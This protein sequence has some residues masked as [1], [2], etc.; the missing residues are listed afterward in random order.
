MGREIFQN[1]NIPIPP[2]WYYKQKG[3]EKFS[4]LLQILSFARAIGKIIKSQG[5]DIA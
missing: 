5:R 2:M 3:V 1:V 4:P